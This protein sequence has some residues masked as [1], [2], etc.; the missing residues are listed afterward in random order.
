MLRE[1]NKNHEKTILKKVVRTMIKIV[2]K[3]TMISNTVIPRKMTSRTHDCTLHSIRNYENH[4]V[5]TP[6]KS[7]N[8]I[9]ALRG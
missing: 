3:I 4:C 8:E 1:S 7:T 6:S 5:T 9:T 2:A